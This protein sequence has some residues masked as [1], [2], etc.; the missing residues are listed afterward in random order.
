LAREEFYAAANPITIFA[1]CDALEAR[2]VEIATLRAE[3][4]KLETAYSPYT[5]G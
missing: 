5:W 3:V 4:E 1:L 2:D